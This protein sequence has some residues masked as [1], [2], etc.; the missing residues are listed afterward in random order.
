[1]EINY[2]T[3]ISYLSKNNSK[4][5]N[6]IPFIT[7]KNIN[8][9]VKP[10]VSS[11]PED[12][13]SVIDFPIVFKNM[14][15]E[16]FFR[17]GIT[18]YDSENNN[19]SF[20]SAII[21][22][23]DKQYIFPLSYTHTEFEII[24]QFKT[25]LIDLY[26]P[27]LLCNYIKQYDKND[28]KERFKLNPDFIVIQYIVEV[29]DINIIIFDFITE[30]IKTVYPQDIMNP[31]KQTVLLANYNLFWEP[32]MCKKSKGS[33]I[34]LFDYNNQ[35]FKKIINSNITYLNDTII[36]KKFQFINNIQTQIINEERILKEK[37]LIKDN[38]LDIVNIVEP[39][40][41]KSRMLGSSSTMMNKP[42]EK[43]KTFSSNEPHQALLD[44]LP[45]TAQLCDEPSS[46]ESLD[47]SSTMM[48]QPEETTDALFIKLDDIPNTKL[49]KAKLTKMKL[50]ELNNL[51][52]KFNITITI[53]NPTK[54]FLI[55][56][57]LA[58]IA[59]E[60]T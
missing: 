15:T 58:K 18:V 34:R 57:I 46:F 35:V 59:N 41:S 42:G 51:S 21:T 45:C 12:A 50:E 23:L 13:P 56:L 53:K 47:S 29:L 37:K 16:N 22:L 9:Y 40:D 60:N 39:L 49:T 32:I 52:K 28:I 17:Y 31:W 8:T 55:E 36:K 33:I 25:Q 38:K 27:K 11:S 5:I 10:L 30:T 54:A 24:N 4:N 20:W 6:T 43:V 7:Q 2:E 19:I 26:N 1:M 14:L 44:E 3:I 48:N